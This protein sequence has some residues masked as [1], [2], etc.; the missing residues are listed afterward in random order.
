MQAPAAPGRETAA[1]AEA[2]GGGGR[3]GPAQIFMKIFLRY[4]SQK[5]ASQSSM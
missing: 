4:S 3:C 2:R 1:G 5:A